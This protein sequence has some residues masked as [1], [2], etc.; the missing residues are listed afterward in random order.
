MGNR[1]KARVYRLALW[2]RWRAAFSPHYKDASLSD[3]VCICL[4][5]LEPSSAACSTEGPK[6]KVWIHQA[7]SHLLIPPLL[8]CWRMSRGQIIFWELQDIF[9]LKRSWLRLFPLNRDRFDVI[10]KP[11][12]HFFRLAVSLMSLCGV[13]YSIFQGSGGSQNTQS[14]HFSMEML[15]ELLIHSIVTQRS[16]ANIQLSSA[17]SGCWFAKVIPFSFG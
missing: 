10:T 7:D 3:D 13:S 1:Q 12:S 4:R 15:K 11:C 9:Q 14:L 8:S 16:K 6:I 2:S 5:T 17:I